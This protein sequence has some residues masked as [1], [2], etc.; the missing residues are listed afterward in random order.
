[1]A[2][3]ANEGG[4]VAG[5]D[6]FAQTTLF[7]RS[8]RKTELKGVK[9][10]L[11]TD[12]ATAYEATILVRISD[13]S[14][15]F[16]DTTML[17]SITDPFAGLTAAE[18]DAIIQQ[19]FE[20]NVVIAL[21]KGDSSTALS[22]ISNIA[23]ASSRETTGRRYRR[24]LVQGE[25]AAE[26]LALLSALEMAA[27]GVVLNAENVVVVIQALSD[28]C[29]LRDAFNTTNIM[30]IF[31]LEVQF[32]EKNLGGLMV[33][34][35]GQKFLQ[36]LGNILNPDFLDYII[37]QDF[38]VTDAANSTLASNFTST[39]SAMFE[40]IKNNVARAMLERSVNGEAPIKLVSDEGGVGLSAQ[41]LSTG[42]AAQ[43]S[44]GEFIGG[45][46]KLPGS[47]GSAI[48][49]DGG[50]QVMIGYSS[51]VWPGAINANDTAFNATA[52][53]GTV[54]GNTTT[55]N[56]TFSSGVHS[57][58][59]G[60]ANGG[61]HDVSHLPEPVD[62]TFEVE[63][64]ETDNNS[65]DV[66]EIFYQA[67]CLYWDTD[68]GEWSDSGCVLKSQVGTIVVCSC[69][70]LTD[71][72]TAFSATAASAD[73]SALTNFSLFT[74]DNI[75]ANPLPFVVLFSL[76]FLAGMG[77]ILGTNVD[78]ASKELSSQRIVH[79]HQFR[80]FKEVPR[81]P[82]D[83]TRTIRAFFLTSNICMVMLST[84]ILFVG[85]N[86]FE[87]T[88]N[89]IFGD[90]G[91]FGLMS[92]A[93]FQL[94][95]TVIGPFIIGMFKG[96]GAYRP[97]FTL[98]LVLGISFFIMN[99]LALEFVQRE[100]I[101]VPGSLCVGVDTA[102]CER[103][104]FYIFQTFWNSTATEVRE[105]V[106][107]VLP[108]NTTCSEVVEVPMTQ[109]CAYDLFAQ[110]DGYLLFMGMS[111]IILLSLLMP[112]G[113]VSYL[114]W[115]SW[116][117]RNKHMVPLTKDDLLKEAEKAKLEAEKKKAGAKVLQRASTKVML[118]TEVDDQAAL[119]AQKVLNDKDTPRFT[120]LKL[121]I[122]FA[123]NAGLAA[124]AEQHKLLSIYL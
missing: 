29:R 16:T 37:Y 112:S 103:D 74:I 63:L 51:L 81:K 120:K 39:L 40:D 49:D 4:G 106:I 28:V 73:F 50:V 101:V 85:A 65:T 57:L 6:G 64:P 72:A 60:R 94:L 34:Q 89:W 46:F 82:S 2:I 11:P 96:F 90:L 108:L 59:L 121:S 19:E 23:V 97:M 68:A 92:Y 71:F 87:S 116:R 26:A 5:F 45:E 43:N 69:T 76:Y 75:L 38:G 25:N 47:I 31:E 32:S 83:K 24:Y 44:L 122:G 124:I 110:F 35:T 54:A 14:G 9:M 62:I 53:N 118:K 70:H 10:P 102:W 58:T 17:I 42:E 98:W 91:N 66:G 79:M 113:F 22:S 77:C 12:G 95:L 27:S 78:S 52:L 8:S 20:D 3:F 105:Q 55:S 88:F 117:K 119:L 99:F 80:A 13:E 67:S 93:C 114:Q 33:P 84:G 1:M 61:I 109:E 111:H 104:V 48:D 56:T 107:E 15:A 115:N 30:R 86:N 7:P 123:A 100:K 36:A 21:Q 18:Q 41:K